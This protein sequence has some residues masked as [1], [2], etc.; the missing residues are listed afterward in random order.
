LIV[1]KNEKYAVECQVKMTTNCLQ[2]SEYF[3]D[4]EDALHW[5]EHE[6]WIFSGEG[7]IC[8]ECNEYIMAN[9]G[10]IRHERGF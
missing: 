1:K 4:E 7:W 6:C 2:T 5:V 10:R 3:D 8:T 9:L